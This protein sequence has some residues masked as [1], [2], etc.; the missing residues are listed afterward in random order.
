MGHL[1]DWKFWLSCAVIVVVVLWVLN[2]PQ[3]AKVKAAI[4][5]A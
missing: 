2:R 4:E 3:A 5:K 1:T